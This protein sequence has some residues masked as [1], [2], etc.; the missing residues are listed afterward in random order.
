MIEITEE[1]RCD[2]I[3]IEVANHIEQNMGAEL[4]ATIW[5]RPKH[6]TL[7]TTKAMS[8]MRVFMFKHGIQR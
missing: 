2:L 1:E 4:I 8:A 5:D 6:T 3:A 7:L